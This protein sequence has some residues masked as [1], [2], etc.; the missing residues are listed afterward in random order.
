[1]CGI[2]F[3]KGPTLL[4]GNSVAHFGLKF[5]ETRLTP[6]VDD[7]RQVFSLCAESIVRRVRFTRSID[8]KEC[9]FV[10][11]FSTPE[12][13]TSRMIVA[14]LFQNL[15]VYV[16]R[17]IERPRCLF[18]SFTT[19]ELITESRDVSALTPIRDINRNSLDARR[20]FT[21]VTSP[22]FS[23]PDVITAGFNA[24]DWRSAC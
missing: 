1:V 17:T 7:L 19:G 4:R 15:G 12:R 9:L 18:G 24:V 11:A 5:I 20:A 16:K 8:P 22:G 14:P 21:R 13:Y 23:V 2:G 10:S 3:A 6:L